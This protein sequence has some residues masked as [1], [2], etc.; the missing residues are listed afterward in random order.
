MQISV[1]YRELDGRTVE[2]GELHPSLFQGEAMQEL[3]RMLGLEEAR[4]NIMEICSYALIQKK[5]R[6]LGL[7][8]Q[9]AMLHMVFKGSPGTGKTT[10]A[11]L[12]GRILKES[13]LLPKGHLV[14]VERADLVGEYI[15]H[16]AMKTREVIQRALGGILF[17]DEAYALAQ[18]GERDFG[19]EAISALVKSMEDYRENLVVILAGY[20]QPMEEF[21]RINPGLKS[22]FPIQLTFRDYDAEELFQIALQMYEKRE[23]I[24]TSRARWKLRE[25]TRRLTENRTADFGNAR[26][27]RNL[28]EQ[29]IR[30]QSVRLVNGEQFTREELLTIDHPDFLFAMQM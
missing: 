13:G 19:R 10:A 22:R 28:V 7:Q 9:P 24:L 15:G 20:S 18:G 1:K 21:M 25:L 14:E 23:Y 8:A 16:T 11:R 29:S 30:C 4:K 6:M 12:Y 3:N 17:L 2:E 27:I 5:R 26:L